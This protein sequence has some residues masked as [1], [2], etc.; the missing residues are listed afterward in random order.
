M[1]CYYLSQHL[2][3]EQLAD[4]AQ[5]EHLNGRKRKDVEKGTLMNMVSYFIK[6]E[7]SVSLNSSLSIHYKRKEPWKF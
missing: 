6:Y 4:C 1:L 3:K 5:G 7:P 2:I